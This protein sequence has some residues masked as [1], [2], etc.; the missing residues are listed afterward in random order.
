MAKLGLRD[1]KLGGINASLAK[2]LGGY[3]LDLTPVLP[4]VETGYHG[5]LDKSGVP[6]NRSGSDGDVYDVATIAQYALALHDKMLADGRSRE[7]ERKFMA[8]LQAIVANMETGSHWRGFF[9]DRHTNLKYREIRTPS[10]SALSQGNA[11]SALLRGFQLSGDKDLLSVAT[12]AFNALS[13]PLEDGG[14]LNVD[15][16]GHL[17]FEEYQMYPPSHVLNGFIFALWGILDYARVTDSRQARDWWEAGVE[18]LQA[19]IA[20]FDRGYWSVYDLRYRELASLYYHVNI[21]VPQLRAMYGL[22]GNAIF[23]RYAERWLGFSQSSWRR[24]RWWLALRID[25]RKRRY[26]FVKGGVIG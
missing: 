7:L 6:L 5:P 12:D 11:I 20:D 24:A 8:Q 4:L 15:S 21:H 13:R 25:A 26:G 19:H 16:C 3:Y 9:L 10:A 1:I 14:V 23:N 2:M 22:T 17:W 18:T